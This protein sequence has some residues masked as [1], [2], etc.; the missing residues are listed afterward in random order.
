[1]LLHVM[2]DDLFKK[3]PKFGKMKFETAKVHKV[4]PYSK[5]DI[6]PHELHLVN[7]VVVDTMEAVVEYGSH[8]PNKRVHLKKLIK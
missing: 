6:I 4:S 2:P 1:M 8:E 7:V 3:L 5:T